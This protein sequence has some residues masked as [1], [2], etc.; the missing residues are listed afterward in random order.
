M[1]EK[2]D[3]IGSLKKMVRTYKESKHSGLLSVKVDGNDYLVKIYFELGMIVGMSM[4]ALKNESCLNELNKC[5]L[6]NATFIKNCKVPSFTT[7]GKVEINHKLEEFF[8]FSPVTGLPTPGK[9]THAINTSIE[10]LQQLEKDVT[11][12]LGPISKLLIDSI[13]ADIGYSHDKEMSPLLY[14][15]LIDRLKRELPSEHQSVFAAK[16][17]IE[18]M[19]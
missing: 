15:Q 12:I 10:H 1:Q 6:V 14:S 11:E 7:V 16:Y 19:F 13:Y 17:T 8:G 2:L 5:K 3:S 4:G 18:P 9:E